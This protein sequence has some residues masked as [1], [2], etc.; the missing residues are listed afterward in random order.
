MG[1][2]Q[3]RKICPVHRGAPV[4]RCVEQEI[5]G[6]SS[7]WSQCGGKKWTGPTCCAGANECVELS[8]WYSQCKPLPT[9][10]KVKGGAQC[11]GATWEGLTECEPLHECVVVNKNYSVCKLK[12]EISPSTAT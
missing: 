10:T 8:E 1:Y 7:V 6:C 3:I 2:L 4:T 12:V 11:G 5:E 9:P